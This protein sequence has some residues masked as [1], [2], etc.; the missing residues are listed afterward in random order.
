VKP[1]AIK[2]PKTHRVLKRLAKGRVAIYWYRSRGGPLMMKFVGESRNAALVAE[3]AGAAELVAAYAAPATRLEPAVATIRTLITKFKVAP[4]GLMK[5]A[6]STQKHWR[7]SLDFID[8]E[9]GDLPLKSLPAKGV[10]ASFIEW[11]NSRMAT[12]RQADIHLDVLK[13]LLSWAKE[14]DLI[15][16]N[17]AAEIKRIYR[18]NRADKI[19]EPDELK[20]ILALVTPRAALAIRLAAATGLRREDLINIKWDFVKDNHITFA[21]GKSRGRKTVSVP[22]HGDAKAVIA[23]LKAERDTK[24]SGGQVPSA[25]VL[26]TEAG[27]R[28]EPDSLTQAFWRAATKLGIDRRLNDLRGTAIT[29][30]VL[31]NVTDEQIAD[32]V[33]WELARVRDIR[34]HYVDA[35]RIARGVATK[36]EM[37]AATG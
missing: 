19:V 22:L 7:R 36:L 29:Q 1:A 12:P 21:T 14:N 11:R 34:K 28:W 13:R 4:D 8:S 6:A 10:K 32:I 33:G 30:F 35:S 15:D 18:S 9:L 25:Y 16:V 5:T 24:L 23:V 27:K 2:L 37:A 26:T 31:A 3:K 17:P 20:A